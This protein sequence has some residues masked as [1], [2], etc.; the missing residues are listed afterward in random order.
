MCRT[1]CFFTICVMASLFMIEGCHNQQE[2]MTTGMIVG[3]ISDP[4]GLRLDSAYV[5]TDPVTASVYS[6]DTGAYQIPDVQPGGY[7]V[8]ASK[9]TYIPQSTDATVIAGEISTADI[10]LEQSTR[11]VLAEM[12]TTACHCADDA[13]DEIYT[14][15]ANLGDRCALLE[16]HAS[17]DPGIETWDP[18][19][20]PESEARRLYYGADT[21]MIGEWMYFNGTTIH[22]APGFYQ[23]AVDSLGGIFSPLVMSVTGSYSS[24]TGTGTIDVDITAVDSISYNDLVIEFGVYDRGPV[25]YAPDSLC[26]I[27]FRYFLVT[28]PAHIPLDIAY[29]QSTNV[30]QS[31]TVPDSIGGNMPPFY[32]VNKSA[33]GV[34]VFIQSAGSRE[35]LQAA[36]IDF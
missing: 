26:V 35:V 1:V 28:M 24:A 2:E 30:T 6:D 16:Y 9:K 17:C 23:H 22:Y 27:P 31:F 18:F 3:V 15:K 5:T 19:V 7:M 29:G 10:T 34:T 13:R 14:I 11:C 20:T 32:R 4:T 8:T 12:L 21:F 36:S 33:I 25:F